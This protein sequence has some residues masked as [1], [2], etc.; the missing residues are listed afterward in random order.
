MKTL[1]ISGSGRAESASLRISNWLNDELQTMGKESEVLD[2]HAAK[3]SLDMN[4][5]WGGDAGL[6][7]RWGAI[8]QQ[9]T[10][11]DS[12]IFVTPEWNGM[13]S[14]SL[15][16]LLNYQGGEMAHK[17]AMLVGVSSGFGGRYPL[18]E[19]RASSV[20]N[21]HLVY[22]PEQL[23][24][25]QCGEMLNEHL[26]IGTDS[27]DGHLQDRARY[28]LKILEQYADALG[29]VRSSGVI[30]AVTYENGV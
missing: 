29:K 26:P 19:L 27:T 21:T 2:L 18:A 20:K 1:I 13:A 12:Y 15:R 10:D 23:V 8:K 25:M 24:V 17:P 7:Q 22:S 14:P 16:V 4:D 3:L 11:A 5:L 30:D 6:G 28:A 9:L